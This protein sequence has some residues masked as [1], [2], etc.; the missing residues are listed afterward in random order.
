LSKKDLIFVRSSKSHF[1]RNKIYDCKSIK[2][3]SSYEV[4]KRSFEKKKFTIVEK[5][6]VKI[7]C[8]RKKSRLRKKFK[9]ATLKKIKSKNY[10]KK[11]RLCTQFKSAA[12]NEIKSTIAEKNL[13]FVQSSTKQL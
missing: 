9:S 8:C 12:L 2:I 1:E 10:R 4:Q 11:S 5:N 6:L 3:S 7:Y 13:V